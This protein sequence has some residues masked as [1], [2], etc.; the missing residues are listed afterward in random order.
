MWVRRQLKTRK[1]GSDETKKGS[2]TDANDDHED[3][4]I[5][6]KFSKLN[7]SQKSTSDNVSI[8]LDD[9]GEGN[10]GKDKSGK[11][12][13]KKGATIDVKH[14]SEFKKRLRPVLWLTPDFPLK[15][16]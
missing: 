2:K 8:Q 12:K 15:A 10:K 5:F 4:M 3:S 9:D 6:R 11:K 13:K 16:E 1:V 7:D 14:E